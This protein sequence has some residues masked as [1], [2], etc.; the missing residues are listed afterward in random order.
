MIKIYLL[1]R[2]IDYEG[3]EVYS[4]GSSLEEIETERLE[5]LEPDPDLPYITPKPEEYV[6][7]EWELDG[8]FIKRHEFND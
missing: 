2:D 4:V 6:I 5:C 1:I 3:S 7:D 8:S